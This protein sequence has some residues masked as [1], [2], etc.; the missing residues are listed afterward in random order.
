MLGLLA[1]A[2]LCLGPIGLGRETTPPE[3]RFREVAERSGL[4]FT[5]RNSASPEKHYIETMPGG[6]AAFDYDSDGE[7]DIFFSNGA[8]IPSLKK[9]TPEYFNRLFRNEGGMRFRDVTDEAGV[10]GEGYSMGAAAADYDNDGNV[11]LFVTGLN[12]NILYHNTGKGRFEDV[13]ANSGIRSGP[14]AVA[15]GWFDYDNDGWLDLFVVHYVQWSLE[16]ERSCGD[17]SRNLKAYCHPR[18]FGELA[19]SLYRSRHD[20]TFEDVSDRSG[21]S[22]FH[23]KGMGVAFADYDR[24]G[25]MDVIVT[26]DYLPN[27]LFRNRGNGTFEEV[28]LAAGVAMRYDGAFI[29]NMGTDFRDY[30]NDGLP[31]VAI[32]ALDGQMFPLFHNVGRGR[33]R[34][35]TQ[36][37][38][39][40]RVSVHHSGWSPAL[41][42]FN[43]D[44]WKDLFA[45]CAHV[46]DLIESFEMARY[47]QTNALFAN[48]G[49]VFEDVSAAAGF[50]TAAPKAHRGAAIADLNHD[51][52]M[53]I[54]VSAL[55]QPAEL[56]E[57]VTPDAGNWISIKLV[58]TRSNRD[59]IGAVVRVDDQW[60]HMTTSFGYSSSSH[61]GL[62]FGL[63]SEKIVRELEIRWPSGVVQRLRNV[64]SNQQLSIREPDPSVREP[65]ALPK[66]AGPREGQLRAAHGKPNGKESAAG[67]H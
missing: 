49:G 33:F 14:W 9:E 34:D 28:S 40:A 12:R 55:N 44:G 8:A 61:H 7:T 54:V 38:H 24:D 3:T 13:T 11:D 4:R 59:G 60:N 45:S 6:V 30:D 46:N 31:D 62:H 26:N 25:Y 43:N 5:L 48:S 18:Y 35:V 58:G 22:R 41:A 2:L 27:F 67:F 56:W 16:T 47:T 21:I 32:V 51:G 23:G 1:A 42:D 63:G 37:S 20:G 57:N 29:S 65:R 15:A 19:N 39:V 66:E 64:K 10:A 53:D 50:G 36:S 17:P 52:K